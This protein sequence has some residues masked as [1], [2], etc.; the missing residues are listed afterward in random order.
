MYGDLNEREFSFFSCLFEVLA[1]GCWRHAREMIHVAGVLVTAR[2][3]GDER[4]RCPFELLG[5]G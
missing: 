5:R 3:T 2:A 1:G 4:V